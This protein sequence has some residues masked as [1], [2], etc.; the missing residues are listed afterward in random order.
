MSLLFRKNHFYSLYVYFMFI[1]CFIT[2]GCVGKKEEKSSPNTNFLYEFTSVSDRGSAYVVNDKIAKKNRHTFVSVLDNIRGKYFLH[3][4]HFNDEKMINDVI[5]DETPTNHGGGSIAIKNT[6]KICVVYSGH[7]DR[8]KY[9]C[10]KNSLDI[11]DWDN[12]ILIDSE[13]STSLYQ[14]YPSIYYDSNDTLHITYREENSPSHNRLPKLVYMTIL[15]DN[16]YVKNYIAGNE[17]NYYSLFSSSFAIYKN[18]LDI[19][20]MGY[21]TLKDKVTRYNDGVFLYRSHDA[22]K[23]FEKIT[24]EKNNSISLT[25]NYYI[26]NLVRHKDFNYFTITDVSDPESHFFMYI[27]DDKNGIKKINLLEFDIIKEL[28]SS[29]L[30]PKVS[31]SLS[32]NTEGN[33]FL[34]MPFSSDPSW[35]SL[36]NK[37]YLFK[38]NLKSKEG[39]IIYQDSSRSW[40]A[41][42]DRSD[43]HGTPSLLYTRPDS[44]TSVLKSFETPHD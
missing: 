21:G 35:N 33:I 34:A 24:I 29:G 10:T 39:T 18:R 42:L 6:N 17:N 23:S 43:A 40:L 27:V 5:L 13:E 15:P 11:N 9:R 20:S 4:Y 30:L 36:D 28:L 1:L 41:N 8:L 22:G 14:T 16:T 2:I 19:L 26:S 31:S 44:V 37:I 32:I 12:P 3:I 25:P 38:L 7:I